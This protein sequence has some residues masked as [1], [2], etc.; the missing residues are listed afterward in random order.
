M[1]IIVYDTATA[2]YTIDN[3]VISVPCSLVSGL[4][5]I[6]L[7]REKIM[8]GAT[9]SKLTDTVSYL[10]ILIKVSVLSLLYRNGNGSG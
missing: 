3:H 6:H 1:H 5:A 7:K 2:L 10:C 8:N 4:S 9:Y